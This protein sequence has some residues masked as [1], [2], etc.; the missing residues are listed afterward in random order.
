MK[1]TRQSLEKIIQE[2]L[3]NVLNEKWKGEPEIAKK[4]KYGKEEMTID[5]LCARKKELK[6][7]EERTPEETTELRQINFALRARRGWKGKEG[8]C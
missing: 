6:K 5:Q 4:D 8:E 2:E 1:I 3:Q 7:K